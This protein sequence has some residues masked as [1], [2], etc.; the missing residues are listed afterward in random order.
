MDEKL[1]NDIIYNMTWMITDMDYH[2]EQTGQVEDSDDM[3]KAKETLEK[4][5]GLKNAIGN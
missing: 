5:K 3:K 4:L 2:N 1:L